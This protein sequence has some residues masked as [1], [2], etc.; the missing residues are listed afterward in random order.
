[1]KD[2]DIE[3]DNIPAKIN[4]SE[5]QSLLMNEF[6]LTQ[7][8]ISLSCCHGGTAERITDGNREVINIPRSIKIHLADGVELTKD[9]LN[10]CLS[11]HRPER[12]DLEHSKFIRAERATKEKEQE[13]LIK[14]LE[15]RIAQLERK[16]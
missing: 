9:Q 7:Q 13:N 16:K 12:D 2:I 11:K 4:T 15:A 5:L 10:A 14:S 6:G 3:A 1:M 8:Q